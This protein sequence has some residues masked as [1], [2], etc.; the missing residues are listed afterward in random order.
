MVYYITQHEENVQYV[1][2]SDVLLDLYSLLF[3]LLFII[4]ITNMTMLSANHSSVLY[5][6][7]ALPTCKL[8]Y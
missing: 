5:L 1:H 3:A 6:A 7:Y 4:N 2:L 8:K